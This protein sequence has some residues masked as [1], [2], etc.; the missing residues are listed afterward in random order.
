MQKHGTPVMLSDMA[1]QDAVQ[2]C[3]SCADMVLMVTASMFM[4]HLMRATCVIL[5]GHCYFAAL[6]QLVAFYG[7]VTCCPASGASGTG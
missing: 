3:A 2:A 7:A 5:L 4:R 1:G 6:L